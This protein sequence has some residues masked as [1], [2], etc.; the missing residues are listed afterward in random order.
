[1]QEL[2]GKSKIWAKK[3][4]ILKAE[5]RLHLFPL[6]C[7]IYKDNLMRDFWQF[8]KLKKAFA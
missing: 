6:G 8:K 1:L 2:E 3:N 4:F 5:I 7:K